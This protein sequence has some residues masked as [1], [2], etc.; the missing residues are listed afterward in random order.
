MPSWARGRVKPADPRFAGAGPG[1]RCLALGPL[2]GPLLGCGGGPAAEGP[3]SSAPWSVY[4]GPGASPAVGAATAAGGGWPEGPAVGCPPGMLRVEGRGRI[5]LEPA[6]VRALRAEALGDQTP[7]Q[8]CEGAPL[9]WVQTDLVDPILRPA[10]VEL[11]PFC[12]DAWPF[13]GPGARYTEDGMTAWDAHQLDVLLKGG[14]LGGRRLCAASELQAAAAGLRLNAPLLYGAARDPARCDG[15][16]ALRGE[17]E[18]PIGVDP[19]CRNPET[20]L[21]EVFTRHAH[22]VVLDAPFV[23]RACAAP[24]C[25]AAGNRPLSAGMFAVLGGTGRLQT[26]QLPLSPHTWHDHGAPTPAGC[27]AMGHDDQPALCADPDP[28]WALADPAL[29]DEEARWRALVAV[30]VASRSMTAFLEAGLGRAVCPAPP[31]AAAPPEPGAGA[32]ARPGDGKGAPPPPGA[33]APGGA[34]PPR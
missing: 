19:A 18:A 34:A 32:R 6:A 15:A 3:G 2:L 7:E 14:G 9:C 10:P 11:A 16:A 25:K 30:A 28:R 1:W 13:P 12:V 31:G 21:G 4:S 24:P 23:A 29:L 26:R 22:W 17:V 20:G 27:D 5:G 33:P 8:A